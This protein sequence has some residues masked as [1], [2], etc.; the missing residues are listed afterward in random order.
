MLADL[1][2]Y[3]NARERQFCT[4]RSALQ[5][6]STNCKQAAECGAYY[7]TQSHHSDREIAALDPMSAS[8]TDRCISSW[9]SPT[10]FP[11]RSSCNVESVC[12]TYHACT[13]RYCGLPS[14]QTN[15]E[16]LFQS[17]RGHH[18]TVS[19]SP[20]SGLAPRNSAGGALSRSIVGLKKSVC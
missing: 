17:Q 12:A 16:V 19:G 2:C 3:S 10:F 7:C 8:P 11:T 5:L 1:S 13:L 14:V 20:T 4:P 9:F 6:C 15:Q 18:R